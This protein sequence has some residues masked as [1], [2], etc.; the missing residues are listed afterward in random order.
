MNFCARIVC[1]PNFFFLSFFFRLPYLSWT[2]WHS[3]RHPLINISQCAPTKQKEAHL[4]RNP[5]AHFK[6]Y[7]YL[8]CMLSSTNA[9]RQTNKKVHTYTHILA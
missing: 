5:L 7:A 8:A 9:H 2:F 6:F 4:V 3:G 1:P